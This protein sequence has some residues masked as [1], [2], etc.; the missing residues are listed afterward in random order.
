MSSFV[1]VS[2]SL[3]L[4]KRDGV[5]KNLHFKIPPPPPRF[6]RKSSGQPS[7][8]AY[9]GDFRLNVSFLFDGF[10]NKA[11]IFEKFWVSC[12]LH[13]IP[14]SKQILIFNF[15]LGITSIEKNVPNKSNSALVK[16]IS[17]MELTLALI[18]QGYWRRRTLEVQQ[19]RLFWSF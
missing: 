2:F 13:Y 14:K 18:I 8:A 19:L 1:I 5:I 4:H 7:Q 17:F 16:T 6:Q 3:H 9:R 11:Y 15:N 12:F 10:P